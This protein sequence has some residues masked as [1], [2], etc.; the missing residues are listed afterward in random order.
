MSGVFAKR[1]KTLL[2]NKPSQRSDNSKESFSNIV[3]AEVVEIIGGG[4]F[5]VVK[6][7][8]PT[9]HKDSIT[10][11]L[12]YP[13]L[14]YQ[15][16][17]YLP[18]DPKNFAD[19]RT[20]NGF[21]IPIPAIGTRGLIV[22]GNNSQ[23][24][25]FW[26]GAVMADGIGRTIPDFSSQSYTAADKDKLDEYASPVGLPGSEF[27]P[28]TNDGTVPRHK[29]KSAI[30]PF[31]E[32]LKKQGLLVDTV[33][34]Q[35]SSNVLRETNAGIFGFNTPGKL[36][37]SKKLIPQTIN[38]LKENVEMRTTR[39]GGHTF[40][41]DDGDSVG[42]NNL[43]RIRSSKGAQILLHDSQEIIYI[44]NQSGSAWFEMTADGKIDVY[45]KDS[46]SIHTE[47]D[48]NF[49]ADRD[50]NIEAGR[51]LNLKGVDR[52]HI[53]ADNLML[54]GKL[55]GQIET[56]GDLEM[57]TR[58]F[59]LAA[60]STS[61]STDDLDISNKR[62]TKIRTGEL[63]LV[64]QF[65]QRYSA[66]T[67]IE[68]KTNVIANQVWNKNNYNPQ[69][70]YQKDNSVVFGTQFFK[71]LQATSV[72]GGAPIPP[73]P[74]PYWA[75][76]PPVIPKTVHGDVRI[77]TQGPIATGSLQVSS[78][79]DIMLNST[80]GKINVTANAQ[81]VY[82]D[83]TQVHLNLPNPL[84][85]L[86]VVAPALSTEIVP[87]DTEADMPTNILALGVFVNDVNDSSLEWKEG[88][89]SSDTPVYS[90]MKRIPQHEPW[91]GHEGLDKGQTDG[92]ATDRFISGK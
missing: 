24:E 15:S 87:F 53:E 7:D 69:R 65:G 11:S 83:G 85:A 28:S 51:H 6:L 76:L 92:S 43:V 1:N 42:E 73:A 79:G 32:V 90:I 33:R 29:I 74:G 71:A 21:M 14:S 78:I 16:S 88:Y 3:Q 55:G 67:G 38:G 77:D 41:M 81:P 49:R 58:S 91:A 5:K 26:I 40:T 20:A 60:N 68:L 30:H 27:I 66:G 61:F 75:I 12:L 62:N 47:T 10:V 86:P 56:R 9:T 2:P 89:Y 44:G 25:G 64:S 22:M 59:K 63:D 54:L 13:Y 36:D 82:V 70:Q 17:N 57:Q 48:F 80:T 52:T 19:T 45:A 50:V 37:K 4:R 39:L 8:G 84:P 23:N 34:G 31:A 18:T 46:V 72:V 35:T